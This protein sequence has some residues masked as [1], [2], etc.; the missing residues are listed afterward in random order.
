M[1]GIGDPFTLGTIFSSPA[2]Q[3]AAT[4]TAGNALQALGHG[5][6]SI[7]GED[8]PPPQ[9]VAPPPPKPSIPLP[10]VIGGVGLAGAALYLLMR[11]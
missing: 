9:P 10:L 8:T 5:I 3:Q 6:L 4:Q 2:V 7:F 11:K 1:A